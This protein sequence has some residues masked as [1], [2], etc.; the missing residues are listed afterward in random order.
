LP[1]PERGGGSSLNGPGIA[2]YS[3][4]ATPPHDRLL[5]GVRVSARPG[6]AI[7]P[8]GSVARRSHTVLSQKTGCGCRELGLAEYSGLTEVRKTDQFL[9]EPG[10]A[11]RTRAG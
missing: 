1:G 2:C 9:R 11:L 5:L 4:T 10:V 7:G 3:Y 6:Q 8:P